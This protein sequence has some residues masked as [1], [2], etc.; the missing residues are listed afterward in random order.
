MFEQ[1]RDARCYH[2]GEWVK[3]PFQQNYKDLSSQE[4]IRDCDLGLDSRE[5]ALPSE[6][7][8]QYLTNHFGLGISKHFMLPYNQKLWGE[9]LSRM[10]TH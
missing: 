7:F 4:I 9:D 2:D 8:E 3:Y 5:N 6:S 1:E 10:G